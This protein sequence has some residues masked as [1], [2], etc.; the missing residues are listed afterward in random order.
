MATANPDEDRLDNRG[1]FIFGMDPMA[2][3]PSPLSLD[4]HGLSFRSRDG[5]A[6]ILEY[7]SDL[8]DWNP[9][10]GTVEEETVEGFHHRFIEFPELG[11]GF[12]RVRY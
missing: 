2:G 9:W 6:V 4:A 3:S 1:E 12:F 8:N 7:S 10:N 11:T 5:S